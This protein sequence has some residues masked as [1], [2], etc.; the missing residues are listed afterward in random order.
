MQRFAALLSRAAIALACCALFAITSAQ[1]L[2]YPTRQP[3]IVVGYPPGGSTDILARL[4]GQYLGEKLRPDLHRREPARRRQ[5]HRHRSGHQGRARWLHIHP[6]Q[7]GQ[8]DQ[9]LALQESQF[10]VPARHRSGRRLHPRAERD[11]SQSVGSGKDRR[12]IHRLCQSQSRQ[13]QRCVLGQW[14]LDPSVRRIVQDDDRRE[15]DARALQRL[16][17]DADRSARRPSAG[18]VRQHAVVDRA[19][20]SR[21]AA[22]ARGDHGDAF[23]RIAGRSDRRRHRAGLRGERVL[24]AWRSER[25]PEGNRRHDQRAGQRGAQGSEDAGEAQ[26]PRRHSDAGL[27]RRFRQGRRRE[28][29]KWEKVVHAANLSIE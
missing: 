19:H 11:G 7:S 24:R 3:H 22:R 14:H 9:R 21:Q 6:R 16:G 15:D 20:Q 4:F 25:H 27:G 5:Q 13:A 29:A 2:D 28:T 12:R 18:D 26:G 17:A 10:R 8:H 1:A 23:A